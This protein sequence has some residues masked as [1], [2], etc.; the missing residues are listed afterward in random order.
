MQKTKLIFLQKKAFMVL[1]S[2]ITSDKIQK[3][4]IKLKPKN[5]T[6]KNTEGAKRP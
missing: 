4:K 6:T 2:R 5:L 3:V 1:I